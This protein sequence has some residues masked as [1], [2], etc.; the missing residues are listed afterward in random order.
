[1]GISLSSES[2]FAY[3]CP[4]FPDLSSN[5]GRPTC[6]NSCSTPQLWHC[7]RLLVSPSLIQSLRQRL[8]PAR[9]RRLP[10]R[11]R[12]PGPQM[13]TCVVF[14]VHHSQPIA[15]GMYQDGLYPPSARM[16]IGLPYSSTE[17]M[18]PYKYVFLNSTRT[19]STF[20]LSHAPS[21]PTTS[22]YCSRH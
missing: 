18:A 6:E 14:A 17:Y 8:R 12:S 22:G 13:D 9:H 7:S 2:R 15:P 4:T 19:L 21:R 11:I 16:P 10:C 20:L 3:H 1:M 5:S